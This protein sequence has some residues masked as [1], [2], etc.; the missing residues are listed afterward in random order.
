MATPKVRE[1]VEE[2]YYAMLPA[3]GNESGTGDLYFW[4][5]NTARRGMPSDYGW[6]T[7]PEDVIHGYATKEILLDFLHTT[8]ALDIDR[9]TC[10]SLIAYSHGQE[11]AGP[12]AWGHSW[13]GAGCPGSGLKDNIL[14]PA[15]LRRTE[16]P[17]TWTPWSHIGLRRWKRLGGKTGPWGWSRVWAVLGRGPGCAGQGPG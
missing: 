5:S 7:R 17:R 8:L 13:V 2:F 16:Q 1:T 14:Q 3:S 6:S 9:G 11:A 10:S 12:P 15:A 4:F